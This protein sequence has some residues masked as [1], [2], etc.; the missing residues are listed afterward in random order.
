MKGMVQMSANVAMKEMVESPLVDGE[1]GMRKESANAAADALRR[2]KG[3]PKEPP[4]QAPFD[5]GLDV[6]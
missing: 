4:S 2:W 5:S 6:G 1:E 3:W